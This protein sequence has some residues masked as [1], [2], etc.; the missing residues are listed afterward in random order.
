M[1]PHVIHKE[2][3]MSSISRFHQTVH[4][5]DSLLVQRH[6]IYSAVNGIHASCPYCWLLRLIYINT[7]LPLQRLIT[8]ALLRLSADV[9]HFASAK[10]TL[11]SPI[12]VFHMPKEIQSAAFLRSEAQSHL[13]NTYVLKALL[14]KTSHFVMCR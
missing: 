4:I 13:E 8:V 14:C 6:K 12:L 10:D 5:V 3:D 1:Q 11:Y 7:T 2:E 9:R